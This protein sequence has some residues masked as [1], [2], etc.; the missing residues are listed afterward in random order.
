MEDGAEDKSYKWLKPIADL[1]IEMIAQIEYKN[2]RQRLNLKS[3][4]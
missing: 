1:L 4:R 2:L 3:S